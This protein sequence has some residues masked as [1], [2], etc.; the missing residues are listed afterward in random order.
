MWKQSGFLPYQYSFQGPYQGGA[1]TPVTPIDGGLGERVKETA[2]QLTIWFGVL[3]KIT[4]LNAV[5][6]GE[7]PNG[8]GTL[9]ETQMSVQ[10]M[11]DALRPIISA[12]F[13]IK[14]SVAESIVNRTQI[15]VRVSPKVRKSLAGITSPSDI[16]AMKMAEK[17]APAYG[18]ELKVKPDLQVKQILTQYIQVALAD[19]RNGQ[20]GLR[21]PEALDFTM[22]IERG[23]NLEDIRQDIAYAVQKAEERAHQQSMEK[24]D[25]QNQGLAAV[26]QQKHQGEMEKI[27]TEGQIDMEEEKI[28][29]NAKQ[30]QQRVDNNQEFYKMLY[31]DAMMAEGRRET[32][33]KD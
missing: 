26:E 24:I 15:A 12:F 22:R 27:I 16:D 2:D 29:A 13:D 21:V 23:E 10:A 5:A 1:A 3:E 28:R 32:V 33:K 25:R 30:L 18:M 11:S 17:R 7:T 14:K 6:L 4:G 19:G 20:P 9:G 8:G 31:E